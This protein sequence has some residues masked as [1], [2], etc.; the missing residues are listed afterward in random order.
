MKGIVFNLLEAVVIK[1]HGED[2]WESVLN[3]A[4]VEGAYTSLGSYPD[5]QM[6]RLVSAASRTLEC[7]EADVLR[8]F[9]RHAMSI[10][11]TRYP[12]FFESQP[13]TRAFLLTLND[14]IHPEVRKIYPGAD[15]PMFDF[16]S[17]STEALVMG[18]HSARKLCA[19]AEGFVGGA[20]QYYGQSVQFEHVKCMHHGDD[21]CVFRIAFN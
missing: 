12:Q 1:E 8:W 14:I 10:L 21:K 5:D 15:V 7:S 11:A 18:Y 19:L 16:D 13:S 20:A 4:A 9:G 6:M 17:S 3:A 2:A